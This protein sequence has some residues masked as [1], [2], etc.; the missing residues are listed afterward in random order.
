MSVAAEN[1]VRSWINSRP[2]VGDGQPLALGAYLANQ[3]SPDSGA[4]AVVLRNPEGGGRPMVAEDSAL[5][6]ARMQAMVFAGTIEAAEAA[7]AALRSE[8]ETLTG[9]PEPCGDTG[10][11]VLVADNLN[12][13]F[14]VPGTG[15]QYCFQVGADFVLTS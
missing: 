3:R 2:I 8:I 12:G 13:P 1:A 7:A 14:A 15:E 9:V 10:V 4:Y 6:V 11:L 5:S